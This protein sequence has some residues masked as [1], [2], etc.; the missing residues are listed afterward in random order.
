MTIW[1]TIV[2]AA[3]VT[4][5]LKSVGPVAFGT[6][7]LPDRVSG[8]LERVTPALL[9]GFVAVQ[10]FGDGTTL[11][12]DERI[13]AATVAFAAAK[14]HTPLPVIFLLSAATVAALRIT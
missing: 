6:K 1:W 13:V 7:D 5:V 12:L 9:A 2:G 4:S 11:V 10:I 8:F 14:M 3:I